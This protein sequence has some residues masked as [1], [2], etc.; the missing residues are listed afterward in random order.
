MA[1]FYM[2]L[3]VLGWSAVPLVSAW[4]GG[5]E[6]PFLTNFAW[7]LGALLYLAAVV[8]ACPEYRRLL[9]DPEVAG[10]LARS[11]PSLPLLFLQL[12]A[13]EYGF[14][15]LSL[16]WLDVSVAAVLLETWP[17]L[18]MVLT[19]WLLRGSKRYRRLGLSGFALAGLAFA[20]YVLVA[21]SERGSLLPDSGF[22][23][24]LGLLAGLALVS[25]ASL[26]CACAGF[27]FRWVSDF[28]LR[29]RELSAIPDRGSAADAEMFAACV[30][31]IVASLLCL[32][33]NAGIGLASGESMGLVPLV[34][35]ALCGGAALALPSFCWRKANFRA[36]DLAIN[37]LAYATPLLS[38]LWLFLLWDVGVARPDLLLF[39]AGAVAV[40]NTLIALRGRGR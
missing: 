31:F 18:M 24:S 15:A 36:G 1:L 6:H 7:R 4:G 13:V 25:L 11:L 20:G 21:A 16:R 8:L 17:V 32:P 19:A 33:V 23:E 12:N 3:T 37:A 10:L 40:S 38:L 39:G 14:F 2:L 9:F 28:V 35:A 5:S 27:N 29:L 26:A 34:L 30:L 22:G